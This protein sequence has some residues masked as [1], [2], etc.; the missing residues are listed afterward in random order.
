[1]NGH[2]GS[3][4]LI[5][6]AKRAV[7]GSIAVGGKLEFSVA[8]GQGHV[9]VNVED[10]NELVELDIP[11]RTVVARHPLAACNEPSGLALD[12][13]SHVLVAACA[14]DVAVAVSARDG[15]VLAI[16]PIGKGPDAVIFDKKN[17]RFLVPCG[18][19][20][21]LT[22]ISE[23]PNGA[24]KV[25]GTVNTAVG[26]RT[27][28]IDPSTGK[29]YLPTADFLPATGQKRPEPAPGSFHI[30]VLNPA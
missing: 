13:R 11:S 29:I 23:Q 12:N 27:G 18:K 14:N 30:L 19:N 21:V 28:A 16:L 9:F 1:M 15:S 22:E 10:K 7:A 6:V 8:D 4:T 17:H 20:G 3:V 5:D 2:D 25:T 24:P 26:A